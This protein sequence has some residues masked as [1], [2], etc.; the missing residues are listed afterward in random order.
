M[1]ILNHT[2]D[3]N[4][5]NLLKIAQEIY[6]LFDDI[7]F[8]DPVSK[9]RCRKICNGRFVPDTAFLLNQRL[10]KFGNHSLADLH[11]LMCGLM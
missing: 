6:P 3:F 11:S 5:P 9:E 4:H 1:I 8:R 2:A 7:T 10:P